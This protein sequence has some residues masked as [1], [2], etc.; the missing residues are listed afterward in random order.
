MIAV[1]VLIAYSWIV[2]GSIDA[3]N[4]FWKKVFNFTMFL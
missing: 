1:I 4:D 3:F 2:V